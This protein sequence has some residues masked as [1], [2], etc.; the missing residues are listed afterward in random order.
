MMGLLVIT[1]IVCFAISVTNVQANVSLQYIDN[2][3]I[4]MAASP[5]ELQSDIDGKK[6]V[7]EEYFLEGTTNLYRYA[8]NSTTGKDIRPLQVEIRNSN[9]PFKTNVMIRRPSNQRDFTGTIH[10]SLKNPTSNYDI[11]YDWQLTRRHIVRDGDIWVGV[12]VKASSIDFTRRWN[13]TTHGS[14]SW[15]DDGLIYGV[16]QELGLKLKSNDSDNPFKDWDVDQVLLIAFSQTGANLVTFLNA[17]H[18]RTNLSNGKPV[19]DGYYLMDPGATGARNLD[20]STVNYVDDRVGIN[21]SK[22]TNIKVIEVRTRTQATSALGRRIFRVTN[23]S[24]DNYFYYEID[25][26]HIDKDTFDEVRVQGLRDNIASVVTNPATPLSEGPPVYCDLQDYSAKPYLFYGRMLR[27]LKIWAKDG[28]PPKKAD[29]YFQLS[30]PNPPL[31]STLP[32]PTLVLDELKRTVGGIRLPAVAVPIAYNTDKNTGAQ[33]CPRFRGSTVP[34]N[35][36]LILELYP[37]HGDYVGKIN[38]A[39]DDLVERK[40]ISFVDGLLV[41]REAAQADIPY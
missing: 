14:L 34:F 9:A 25:A 4:L 38:E 26:P 6:F 11:N 24:I 23:C 13:S 16:T 27:N 40:Y 3:G 15:T 22:I 1:L 30:G 12:S 35:S 28:I 41:H 10:L 29:S 2:N 17:L 21:C 36:T 18:E 37:T 5:H 20:G 8:I 19:F 39:C 7:E 31:G 33:F 32:V